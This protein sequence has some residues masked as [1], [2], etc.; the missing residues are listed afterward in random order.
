MSH[1]DEVANDWDSPEKVKLMSIIAEKA[2]TVLQIKRSNEK[3]NS[4]LDFGCGTGLF[5]LHFLPFC[6][7]LYGIDTSDAMLDVFRKKAAGNH[8]IDIQNLNLETDVFDKK[9]DLI[10]SSMVLHHITD[11]ERLFHKFF[12]ML[13]D[14]GRIA[15]VDLDQED[16]TF[17]P[18]NQKM[19]VKHFGFNREILCEWAK[20]NGFLAEHVILHQIQ[21]EER[22]YPLFLL[23]LS[24][25]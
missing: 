20:N 2:M 23:T 13:S 24:K 5:G 22:T 9:I 19:G 1:F 4:I 25:P 18:D 12:D 21:K 6:Q 14:Q 16:G 17:H 8:C 3:I 7:Y 10:V 15:I 11:P